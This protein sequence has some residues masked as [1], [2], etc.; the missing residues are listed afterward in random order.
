MTFIDE[1][2]WLRDRLAGTEL[3][4]FTTFSGRSWVE[5]KGYTPI[6]FDWKFHA[7]K[8]EANQRVEFSLP[9][10]VAGWVAVREGVAVAAQSFIEPFEI[11][12]PGD[13]IRVRPVI[14]FQGA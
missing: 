9:G 6:P 4:L 10:K 8:A 5:A 11:R 3:H 7:D 14:A 1:G 13:A 12:I 2:D